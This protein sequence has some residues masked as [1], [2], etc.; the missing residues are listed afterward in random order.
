MRISE[1][2]YQTLPP[3][4]ITFLLAAKKTSVRGR[5]QAETSAR[6]AAETLGDSDERQETV[7]MS[8]AQKAPREEEEL[9]R[10]TSF[11]AERTEEWKD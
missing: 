6:D 3:H 9:T 1:R 5:H 4:P 11:R 10:V 2:S 7:N 8:S